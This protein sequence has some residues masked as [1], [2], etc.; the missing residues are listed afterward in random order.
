MSI[1]KSHDFLTSASF[2]T[3]GSVMSVPGCCNPLS[4]VVV[5][6]SGSPASNTIVFKGKGD[7]GDYTVIAATNLA[8][9]ATASQTL[10]NL[11]EKW[12]IPIAGLRYVICDLTAISGSVTAKGLVII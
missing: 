3:S 1:F 4:K 12:S 8:T 7:I 10:S 6:I 11:E 5:S 2:I 9:N